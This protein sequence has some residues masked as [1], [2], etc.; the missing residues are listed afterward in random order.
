MSRNRSHGNLK[1]NIWLVYDYEC[2]LCDMYCRAIRIK[3]DI[4]S[5]HLVD[6]RRPNK[7]MDEITAKGIDIDNGMVLKLDN[8]IYYGS[9][10]IHVLTLLSTPS[11]VFNKINYWVFSSKFVARMLYPICRSIRNVLLF[12]IMKRKKINNLNT[13]LKSK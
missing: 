7:L 11:G 5:L 1:K 4:G 2:P 3:K 8:A 13:T 9:E 10:A 12:N 6:A